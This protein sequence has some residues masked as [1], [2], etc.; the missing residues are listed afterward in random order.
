MRI[1]T[2][3]FFL[4]YASSASAFCIQSRGYDFQSSVDGA[5]KWLACLHDEQT[6]TLNDHAGIINDH[7]SELNEFKRSKNS[8]DMSMLTLLEENR[9][10]KVDADRARI[11]IQDLKQAV[12]D[13]T[14]RLDELERKN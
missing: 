10:L 12:E 14:A 1:V 7:T 11:N 4:L 2:I 8:N 5:V 6:S 3:I 9:K 13:L